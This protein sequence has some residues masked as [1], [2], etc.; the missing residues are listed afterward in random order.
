MRILL[1]PNLIHEIERGPIARRHSDRRLAQW[2]GALSPAY[3]ERAEGESAT[4]ARHQQEAAGLHASFLE[5]VHQTDGH[6]GRTHVAVLVHGDDDAIHAHAGVLGHRFDDT[7]VGLVRHHEIDVAGRYT[8][9]AQHACC[10]FAHAMH[11]ALEYHLPVEIPERV[12]KRNAAIRI[13]AA[14]AAHAQALACFSVAAEYRAD[15]TF[16]A[17]GGL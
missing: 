7:Q 3:K 10:R 13:A 15:H 9:L 16:L 11:G 17:V 14:D 5:R 6:G 12:A 2:S 1:A 8:G 4:E